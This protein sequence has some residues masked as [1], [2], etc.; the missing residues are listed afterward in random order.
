MR[1]SMRYV[2]SSFTLRNQ[3]LEIGPRSFHIKRQGSMSTECE[4]ITGKGVTL[5]MPGE[6]SAV[7]PFIE[8]PRGS[9]I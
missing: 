2:S 8:K 4:H 7:R 9:N 5:E 3:P 1:W 6:S